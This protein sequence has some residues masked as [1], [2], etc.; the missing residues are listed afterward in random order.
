MRAAELRELHRVVAHRTGATGDEHR[1]ACD[2]AVALNG[3]IRSERRNAEA[4]AGVETRVLRQGNRL[5]GGQHHVLSRRAE[6]PTPGRV[7]DPDPL[8]DALRR[9]SGADLV[10]EAGAVTVRDH[11]GERQFAAAHAAP[12]LHVG[13]VDARTGEP[14]AHLAGAGRGRVDA[15]PRSVL[16]GRVLCGCRKRQASV[17]RAVAAAILMMPARMQDQLSRFAVSPAMRLIRGRSA[18]YA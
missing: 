5:R 13:R 2:A 3:V 11:P 4:R 10:D 17:P 9:D 12:C 16:R 7:P 18:A 15:R 8:A 1:L 14:D 6:G